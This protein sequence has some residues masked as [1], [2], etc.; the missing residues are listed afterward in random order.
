MALFTAMCPKLPP[1]LLETQSY[2]ILSMEQPFQSIS[3]SNRSTQ[4]NRI[5]IA[6]F[7]LCGI[8]W[9]QQ[10]IY[11]NRQ[12]SNQINCEALSLLLATLLCLTATAAPIARP[13]FIS[14]SPDRLLSWQPFILKLKTLF[15]FGHLWFQMLTSLD[16]LKLLMGH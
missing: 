7:K 4:H 16:I 5:I 6:D 14:F 15:V 3:W 8:I 2:K 11:F 12:K 1:N 13:F 9:Y 10:S